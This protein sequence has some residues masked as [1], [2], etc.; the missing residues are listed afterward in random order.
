VKDAVKDAPLGSAEILRI[1]MNSHA[2]VLQLVTQKRTS[3][4]FEASGANSVRSALVDAPAGLTSSRLVL[5]LDGAAQAPAPFEV[6]LESLPV[7]GKVSVD[8]SRFTLPLSV[9]TGHTERMQVELRAELRDSQDAVLASARAQIEV[10]PR[11]HWY[12]LMGAWDTI[13][14]FVTPNAVAVSD[15]LVDASRRLETRTKSS[16]L[17]GYQSGS[18]E[19]ALRI[20]EACCE[21]LAAR[22]SNYVS[23]AI[24][25]DEQGQRLRTIAE[26]LHERMGNC[27]DMACACA[28][29]FERAGLHPLLIMGA[30]HAIVGFFAIDEHFP[31]PY[32][33]GVSRISNRVFLGELR[34]LD[35]TVLTQANGSF[36][37]A[38]TAGEQW[39]ESVSHEALHVVDIRATRNSGVHPLP[40]KLEERGIGKSLVREIRESEL[41]ARGPVQID[42]PTWT[43]RSKPER[44]LE[45]W[46]KQLLDLT[47]RNRL[48]NDRWEKLGVPLLAEGDDALAAIEDELAKERKL[49]LLPCPELVESI[50]WKETSEQLRKGWLGTR[51]AAQSLYERTTKIAREGRSSLEESG[52]RSLYVAIGFLEFSVDG[53]PGKFLAPLLLVPVDLERVSRTEGYRVVPVKDDTVTNAALAEY[54]RQV[55]KVELD[56]DAELPEDDHGVDVRQLLARVRSAVRDVR[57][58]TVKPLAKLGTWQF[59]KLPLV[60]ELQR[61]RKDL[62]AHPLVSTLLGVP[63]SE[64]QR[65]AIPTPDSVER[66]VRRRDMRLPLP[67]DSSQV[68]AVLAAM[69][70]TTFVLQGPPG[71]GKSQTITN[72]LCEALVRG[73][74]VLFLAEKSAAL[75]V[76]AKRLA[77]A[78][79]AEWA[80]NL[81]PSEANRTRFLAQIKQGFDAVDGRA[82]NGARRFHERG[83]ALD[84]ACADLA[85]VK[86]LLHD[87]PEEQVPLQEAIDLAI[88]AR[89]ELGSQPLRLD[90]ALATPLAR[91]QLREVGELA[92]RLGLAAEQV[93]AETATALHDLPLVRALT[94]EQAQAAA[95]HVSE[96]HRATQSVESASRSLAQILSVPA[97]VDAA[98]ARRIAATAQ[99]L[100]E[101]SRANALCAEALSSRSPSAEFESLERALALEEA[102]QAARSD[103]KASWEDSAL[104]LPL[105]ALQRELREAREQFFISAWF[106]R[107]RVRKQLVPH[108][109]SV[110]RGDLAGLDGAVAGLIRVKTAL[111]ALQPHAPI[112]EKLAGAAGSVDVAAARTRLAEAKVLYAHLRESDPALLS[113]LA[114]R[115]GSL[116]G[117]AQVASGY[118]T[119]EQPLRSLDQQRATAAASLG[120]GTLAEDGSFA[121]QAAQLERWLGQR[122]N[123]D[124]WSRYCAERV[125]ARQR[126]LA[127]LAQSLEQGALHPRRASVAARAGALQ[128]WIEARLRREVEL[129]T[130]SGDRATELRLVLQRCVDEYSEGASAAVECV[131]RDRARAFFDA[132]D[133]ARYDAARALQN[134]R[135]LQGVRRTIRHLMH[136]TGPALLELK[137]LVLASPLSAAQFLPPDFPKFDLVV[138]DE[139]SQVPVWDAACALARGKHAVVVGDS[140]QLPPTSFFGLRADEDEEELEQGELHESVLDGCAGAALPQLSLLWHYRSRDERLIEFAN[141]RSYNASLQTF[142]APASSH[143]NLGVEFR[144]VKGTY[145][146]AGTATNEIEARAVVAE[147]VRRLSDDDAC[148]ANRSI[149][150]VTFSVAQQ[151]L[152]ADLLDEALDANPRASA[153]RDEAAASGEDLF[154]KNLESVQGDERATMLF[155][156]GYGPDAQGKIYY[157]FGPL[158]LA[159]GERRLNVAITRAKEKVIVFSSMRASQLD[160][161]RCRARGVQ[162]LR[163]YLEYAE[164]GVVPLLPSESGARREIAPSSIEIELAERLR[165]RGWKVDLHVGRSRDYRIS[166]ALA[167]A[168]EPERWVLGVELDGAHW[169]NAPTTLDREIV[170][171]S[172]LSGL[173]WRI[174]RVATVD[175]WRDLER[176]V[177]K[178]D[179]WARA[180]I[181]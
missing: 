173:G 106:T 10:M 124:I 5:T 178:I 41:P 103:L 121:D 180:P 181:S 175:C 135:S 93:G 127:P 123:W 172:V 80:L 14:A 63:A 101:E 23:G 75:E 12:G 48:L 73:K 53:K 104:S 98:G 76:V 176:V 8:L 132:P 69:S 27:V 148:S 40:E 152:V 179:T 2:P 52:A 71:T 118:R 62:L 39:L 86:L 126:G 3:A 33:T 61:R 20:A 66:E 78:G 15:V 154:V 151:Q 170:R 1:L 50:G 102:A 56:L 109:K 29:L 49:H 113:A 34:V 77:K 147:V 35:A 139:A 160:P 99:F 4:V 94:D 9:L 59:R 83:E 144:L 120:L 159:G 125:V 28:S 112:L 58:C 19:K 68:A 164:L 168:R 119:L 142:P 51:I 84:R 136:Q 36:A 88:A 47:L 46:V 18:P 81:H 169:A 105:P 67:A 55:H 21:A 162:D 161:V 85:R 111:D 150:V 91:S 6:V 64:P 137:P 74:R 37:A 97:P 11:T 116:S 171:A 149:G 87:A 131:V 26:V 92:Q 17:D 13:A 82:A 166:L 44:N 108:A 163:S 130:C 30:G 22:V 155:S 117:S 129:A 65:R 43:E 32:H 140:K 167:D 7:G 115:A 177:A 114:G 95:G 138:I 38:I 45:R 79:L 128:A 72:L 153:R 31:E 90:G 70:D 42:E 100:A 156:I 57:G 134:L 143:P 60:Q 24:R 133:S 89:R 96:L 165:A 25:F 158:G 157:N 146:R 16:S 122:S 141:R 145:D 54:M 110:L 107:R 174:V